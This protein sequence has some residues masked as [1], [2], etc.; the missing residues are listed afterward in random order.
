[1]LCRTYCVQQDSY[2]TF[3]QAA[4]HDWTYAVRVC[5]FSVSTYH[6]CLAGSVEHKRRA[7]PGRIDEFKLWQILQKEKY[8][9][10]GIALWM[11]W[12]MAVPAKDLV[13]LTWT[14]VDLD[15]GVL[16]LPE[17]ERPLTKAVHQLLE[18]ERDSR[19]AGSDPHILLSP[20]ARTPVDLSRLSKLVQ[21]A[22]IRGGLEGVTLRDV[23]TAGE[24]RQDEDAILRRVRARGQLSRGDVT[25]L[26]GLSDTAAYQRLRRMVDQ[27]QLE[28]VGNK[29]YLPGTVVPQ[30]R[31]WVVIWE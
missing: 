4:L 19:P 14:Q 7:D 6:S 12:Q 28:A 30:D 22:L 2:R 17:G 21:T 11:S 3:R 10:E 20:V 26:L 23:K 8:T 18:W 31:Q 25:A 15:R 24:L 13:E 27:G 5:G 1:M 16:T 29:Y 9:A